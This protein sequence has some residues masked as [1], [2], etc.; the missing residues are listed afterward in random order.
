MMDEGYSEGQARGPAF[1]Y[2]PAS[3]REIL[4]AK[5]ADSVLRVTDAEQTDGLVTTSLERDE[6]GLR[7]CFLSPGSEAPV[8][9]LSEAVRFLPKVAWRLTHTDMLLS[10]FRSGRWRGLGLQDPDSDRL[11]S[12]LDYTWKE[13]A[14]EIEVGFCMTHPDWRG[15]GLVTRLLASLLL[16]HFDHPVRISTHETN[17]AMSRA[18]QHFGFTVS[19]RLPRDRINGETTLYLIR[20]AWTPFTLKGS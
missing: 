20:N 17:T 7:L 12:Y 4:R 16:L 6:S 1:S 8:R 15:R 3:D 11:V 13:E 5:L 9:R 14:A 10:G 19:A 2:R 18:L